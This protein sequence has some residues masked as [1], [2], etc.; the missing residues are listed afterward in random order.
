MVLI[1]TIESKST[2][3]LLANCLKKLDVSMSPANKILCPL[4][5]NS[6]IWFDFMNFGSF[7]KK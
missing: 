1:D 4:S 3:K 2:P 6:K 7:N 5:K